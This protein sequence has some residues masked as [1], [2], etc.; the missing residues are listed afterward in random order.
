MDI[1]VCAKRFLDPE[2]AGR[3]FWIGVYS[4]RDLPV[5]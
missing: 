1:S 5:T 2:I 4:G 3:R